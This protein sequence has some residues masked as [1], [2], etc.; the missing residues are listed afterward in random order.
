MSNDRRDDADLREEIIQ[1]GDSSE[2]ELA[3]TKM[4][5][6]RER[7][8][9]HFIKLTT[10]ILSV[11]FT[12]SVGIYVWHLVAPLWGRWLCTGDL[13]ALRGLAIT[14]I[15]GSILSQMTAYFYQKH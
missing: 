11:V 14:I 8:V 7:T 1:A 5:K 4:L 6:K 15:T 9:L 12:I 3:H 10:L 13:E 2:D